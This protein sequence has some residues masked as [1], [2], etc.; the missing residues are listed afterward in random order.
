MKVFINVGLMG[1][2]ASILIL[3]C[4]AQ[5]KRADFQAQKPVVINILADSSMPSMAK[6]SVKPAEKPDSLKYGF[7]IKFTGQ[8]EFHFYDEDD[9]H[10]GPATPEE[11]LPTVE[12][13]LKQPS[14]HQQE[15]AGLENIKA[16]IT[17]TGSAAEFATTRMIPNL[18]YQ[19]NRD[20]NLTA[21][22]KGAG[23]ITLR[24]RP[25]DGGPIKISLKIWND[26]TMKSAVYDVP[27][28][29]GRSGQLAVSALM[30]DF[31]ISWDVNGDGRDD[32]ELEPQKL[33]S[34]AVAD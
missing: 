6:D 30:D 20:G 33:D 9:R 5:P 34:A 25:G 17:R 29:V 27:Q 18:Y 13:L 14:L 1:L 7:Q 21:E 4:N 32:R 2:L 24:I 15:R 16:K 10:T 3:G 8:G 26:K 22:F 12:T 11:Y 28:G 19:M 23:E 31:V